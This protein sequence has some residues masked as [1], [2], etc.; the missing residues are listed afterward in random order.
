MCGRLLVLVTGVLLAAMACESHPVAPDSDQAQESPVFNFTSGPDAG[1][2]LIRG[3]NWAWGAYWTDEERQM[4][5]IVGVDIEECSSFTTVDFQ[6]HSPPSDPTRELLLLQGDDLS[7]SVW[8][9]T[10]FDCARFLS[11]TPIVQGLVDMRYTNNDF[12][13]H[14][15]LDH[16]NANAFGFSVHGA[17][18][19]H[20]RCVWDGDDFATMRCSSA[21]AVK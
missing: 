17:F 19:G 15:S 14:P 6:K 21:I 11:E 10:Q 7:A 3:E 16:E 9:F 5:A 8:P 12:W 20:S 13:A 18:S 2:T 1:L 4:L